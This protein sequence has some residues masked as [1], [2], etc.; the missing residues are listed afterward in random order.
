MG[1]HFAV[2]QVVGYQNSGKTVLMEKLIARAAASGLSAGSLKHHGHGGTPELPFKDSTK[3]FEAGAVLSG[4]E[5]EG[6]LQFAAKMHNF[7]PEKL[8]DLYS[9]FQLDVLFI[10]G[11]KE[12]PF[13]KAVLISREE[14]VNLISKLAG[15]VCVITSIPL[16]GLNGIKLFK[17]EDEDQ[18]IDFLMKEVRKQSE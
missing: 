13:P 6:V 11:Y 4:A 17:R 2:L 15:V 8:L 16:T 3:H 7:S 5:G 12:K 10:E 18:Y 1:K 9:F 14:D